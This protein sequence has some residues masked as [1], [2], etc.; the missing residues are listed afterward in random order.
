M[1]L[2]GGM[3]VSAQ[4]PK[5]SLPSKAPAP[6]QQA[7]STQPSAELTAAD[8][9]AFFNGVVPVE[10]RRSDIAGAT[11]AVVKDGKVVF[12]KGY[13][14]ADVDAKKP[15]SADGTLFRPG[16]ISKLF[17]W[18]AVMQLVEQGKLDLDRDVNEY[19]D[20][21]IPATYPQP[22]TLRNI[23]T[24]TPG[25]SEAV[26]DLFVKDAGEMKPLGVYLAN[27]VPNRIFPPGTTPAYSNYA[28]TI[29]GY[30]VERVSGKPFNEYIATNI[31]Q[32][33][34]MSH[35]TFEQPLPPAL[36]PL[37]SKGYARASDKAK[38]FEFVQAWPAGSVATSAMDMT[39]FMIAHLQNGEYNGA[40]ILRP[41]TAGLMHAR[42]FGANPATNAMALGFYEETR[43]GHRIIGHGGDTGWFHSD[44]H[45][46]LDSGVGFFV[47]YNSAGKGGI[48][49][50]TELFEEFLDRYFPYQVQPVT[51]PETAIADAKTVSGLYVV[52]RR[53]Q[54]NMLEALG[55][56]SEARVT[57]MP[58]GKIMVDA[59]KGFNGE[60][61]K[62]S[63]IAP[64]VYREVDGQDKV[65]FKRNPDG[66]FQVAIDYPFMV[67]DRVGLLQNK[68]FNYFILCGS[69]GIIALALIFWPINGCLRRHYGKKLNLSAGDQRLRTLTRLVC[70]VNILFVLLMAI[71]LSSGD[72]ITSF[73]HIGAKIHA[74]QIIGVLGSLGALIVLYNALRTWRWRPAA[75]VSSV[76]A[77][78]TD[79][80]STA[81][82]LSSTPSGTAQRELR[83][84]RT[85]E[86]L[87]ALACLG[88]VWFLLYWNVLDFSLHF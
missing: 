79:S 70:A 54:G 7:A 27:H 62:F 28:T 37:M 87:I 15:V 8:L 45:L 14:Y 19:L 57:A 39:H 86:T 17:T 78:S 42:Q 72:G 52:S 41:E 50:R 71:V 67:F 43:N 30:I 35:T 56:F 73:N 81:P 64:L 11:V 84:S 10:L 12:A 58:D 20:F 66:G 18:T 68:V 6:S 3:A 47:S 9:D 13:G 1:A 31:F 76:A 88:F 36:E 69:L 21:K 80:S 48:S 63:E 26:K 74:V 65:A 77:A 40:H 59:L 85:F 55:M 32:P 82:S 16:S 53:L 33:L 29:A 44:L 23:M 24:H 5:P 83:P 49:N 51:A 25:F 38:P 60:P 75:M 46:I 61:K 34:G 2:L 4:G 22:I